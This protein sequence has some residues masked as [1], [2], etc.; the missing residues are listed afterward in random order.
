VNT[1]EQ[2]VLYRTVLDVPAAADRL[3]AVGLQA[4]LLLTIADNLLDLPRWMTTE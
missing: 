1:A 4:R 3:A 2:S